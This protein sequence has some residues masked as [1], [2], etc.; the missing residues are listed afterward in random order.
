M[1]L[2]EHVGAFVFDAQAATFS[3]ESEPGATRH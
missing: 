2:L 3:V 1:D